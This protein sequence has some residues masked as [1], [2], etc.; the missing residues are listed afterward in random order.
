[1]T[2]QNK[3][4]NGTN[5][6]FEETLWAAADKMRNNMDPAEYKHVVLGLIFLKYISDSFEEVAT[7]I[8]NDPEYYAGQEEDKDAYL[9]ENVFWV[10][11][12]ARWEYIKNN[13][14]KPEIGKIIDD[15]MINI[16]KDNPNLKG[17]L[18][19]NYAKSDL[20][21]SKLGELI[22]LISTIT[23]GDKERC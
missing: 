14:K 10:P 1:M 21:K 6:G 15:A 13:A 3:K 22:D 5:V 16:E 2:K 20:D 8:K 12:V 18:S 23:M 7:K 9:A 4:S 17:V 11:Q 19:K